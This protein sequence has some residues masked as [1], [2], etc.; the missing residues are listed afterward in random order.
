[1]ETVLRNTKPTARQMYLDP[2]TKILLCLTVS[3]VTFAAGN[4]GIMRYV[5]PC[6]AVV[7]L[8]C[9]V[10]LKKPLLSVYYTVM[11]IVSMTVPPLLIPYAPP[12]VNV[13]FTGIVAVFTKI[14]PGMSMFSFLV[15][16]TTVSEFVAAMDGLHISKKFTIPVSVMF[17]FFPTI[18]DEY[19]AIQ[20]AMRLRGVGSWKSPME[21]LE[22]RIVP[23]LTGLVSIG[24]ELSASA[25]TRGLNAPIRRTNMCPVGFHVQDAF[26]FAFCTCVI[27]LFI[28]SATIGL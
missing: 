23:L 20:D 10:I 15:V 17:R 5:L 9:F 12:W 25:L 28:L 18:R 7:P 26:A 4:V 22:Y 11:Y 16:T 27:V 14:L 13:F 6:H 24:N 21:M 2:R 8:I 1:M 19:A 3:S